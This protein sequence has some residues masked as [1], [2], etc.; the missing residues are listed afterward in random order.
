MK[1][2][3]FLKSL[4][5]YRHSPEPRHDDIQGNC[6]SV[7][8]QLTNLLL[9]YGF[10]ECSDVLNFL[11]FFCTPFIEPIEAEFIQKK[12]KICLINHDDGGPY[13]DNL[14]KA[15]ALIDRAAR[16]TSGQ[17]SGF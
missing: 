3:L 10:T 8:K 17:V 4:F 6:G 13:F 7:K 5:F 12:L 9:G 11:D 16:I 14:R 1:I 15:L 2:S